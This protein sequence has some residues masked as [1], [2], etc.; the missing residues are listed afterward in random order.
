MSKDTYEQPADGWV[1]FHCGE[2]FTKPGTAEEHFGE[3]PEAVTACLAK[4]IDT[5][6]CNDCQFLDIETGEYPR[7]YSCK[8]H[9]IE[10]DID[11]LI[12]DLFCD[13][14]KKKDNSHD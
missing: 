13:D 8:K 4:T 1:C 2:R 12:A 7:T 5:R 6:S 3:T 9:N 14:W 10:L 11:I